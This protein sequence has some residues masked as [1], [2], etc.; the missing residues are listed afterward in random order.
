MT[1]PPHGVRDDAAAW[2]AAIVE[3]SDDA[4]IGKNLQGVIRSWNP[5]AERLFGY[6][7][8][9]VI[10]QSI[11][12]LFPVERLHEEAEFLRRIQSGERIEH[13]ET[14][15][16]RKDGAHVDVSITLSPI[17]APGGAIVGASKIARDITK[18]K[19]AQSRLRAQEKLFRIT[20]DS[21][22]DGV[23][24]T[25]SE[26]CMTF[27]NPVAERLT[28]W[29]EARAFGQPVE[30]VFHIVNETTGVRPENPVSRALREGMAVRLANPTVLIA[31]DG[32]RRPIEDSAAPILDD[33]G[34]VFGAVLVF[35]DVTE[36]RRHERDLQLLAAIVASSGDAFVSK[37]LDGV[38]T[39][40][41]P[42]A[43]RMFGYT[44]DE[45]IGQGISLIV[46][47]DRVAEERALLA[48]V[49]RAEHVAPFATVRVAKDGR[50]MDVDL[51]TSPVRDAEG[52]ISGASQIARDIS[53]RQRAEDMRAVLLR[54]AERARDEAAAAN[55]TKDQFLAILSHELRTP[56][57]AMLGWTQMLRN[58]QVPAERT[59]HA[60]DVIHRNTVLQARL[61][62]D[63]LDVARIEAG[64]LHLDNQPVQLVPLIE[65]AVET[66]QRDAAAQQLVLSRH[67]DPEAGV[68]FGDPARVEQ[69]VVNLLSNAVKFTPP[70]GR[71]DLSLDRD[72]HD[73]RIVVTDT[74]IGIK[75]D[76]VPYIFERFTQAGG[77]TR[78]A[79]G[80]LGLGLAIVR[81]LVQLH[82]GTVS[83]DSR[84]EGHGA[85][86]TVRLPMMAAPIGVAH[87]PAHHAAEPLLL[88]GIKVVVVEDDAD[89]AEMVATVLRQHRAEVI[90]TS[91]GEAALSLLAEYQPH[92]LVCD[93]GLPD[94]DGYALMQRVRDLER[95]R[96]RRFVPS[97]ALTAFASEE[98]RQRAVSVG[99]QVHVSKPVE[100]ERLVEAVAEVLAGPR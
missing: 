27:M 89:A 25:D 70:G 75:A 37:T 1:D 35:R 45:A 52:E 78:R 71:V 84:G 92:V 73:A 18:Q 48:R 49:R 68:V 100:P 85:T 23:M 19:E 22:G 39:S 82:G 58:R 94:I 28:G 51:T 29:T 11:T 15:R 26:G 32:T 61:I 56:L 30:R 5:G 69:I 8:H 99:Y 88:D 64:K 13:Y 2:L 20:L 40:W 80:G 43:E 41:S 63:L 24:S 17:A 33:T 62:D 74:G 4:I 42:G 93:I 91:T 16:V 12:I 65:G 96:G 36:R 83:A 66:L 6:R 14:V 50:R 54:R 77:G 98:E 57:A 72:G 10:G 9:D 21:I 79:H 81:H 55:R 90:I 95:A 86:F 87:R 44:R 67:L 38:I 3:S 76:A 97:V 46:P 7:A 34:Q 47:P 59:Q 31:R 60:L 53:D